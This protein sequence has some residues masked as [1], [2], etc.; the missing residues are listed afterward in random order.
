MDPLKQRSAIIPN[1]IHSLDASHLMNVINTAFT[2]GI[3]DLIT[4][5][6]CFGTH[7][8]NLSLLVS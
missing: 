4:V 2:K 3:N 5:H 6:D 1:V 8:N 7:P